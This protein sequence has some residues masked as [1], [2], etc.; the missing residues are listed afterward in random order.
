M[1]WR[2][3]LPRRHL[4]H[5]SPHTTGR[6]RALVPQA[7]RGTAH[8]AAHRTGDGLSGV[9]R[10]WSVV[11]LGMAAACAGSATVAV[12]VA[13]AEVG[14]GR[15]RP[16]VALAVSAVGSRGG[17]DDVDGGSRRGFRACLAALRRGEV[18]RGTVEPPRIP[19]A[20]ARPKERPLDGVAIACVVTPLLDVRPGRLAG[21]V[22]AP[23][24]GGRGAVGGVA[25]AVLPRALGERVVSG[26][27]GAHALGVAP[28]RA[29]GAAD[30][31]RTP[32]RWPPLPR[33]GRK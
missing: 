18:T 28:S 10:V 11:G 7:P 4:A 29:T 14:V 27:T 9:G 3:D 25:A 19:A 12:A 2:N 17:H 32:S 15:V 21:A 16:E 6:T 30:R 20:G 8:R 26:G 1:G 5:T 31:S 24:R 23:P 22:F 13:V 33:M